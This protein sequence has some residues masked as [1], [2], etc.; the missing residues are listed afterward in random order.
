[1]TRPPLPT[2]SLA[3]QLREFETVVPPRATPLPLGLFEGSP[4]LQSP[5]EPRPL[6]VR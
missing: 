1:M 4:R 6:E 2:S 5:R 3:R